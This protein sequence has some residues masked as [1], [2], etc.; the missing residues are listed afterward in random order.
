MAT[1]EAQVDVGQGQA[2]DH[3]MPAGPQKEHEWLQKLVGEWTYETEMPMGPD[4]PVQK[5]QGT[6]RVRSIGGLWVV[7]EGQGEMPG[8]GPATMIVTIG[9]DPQKKSY[10]GTWV[11]S[12]M[13]TLWIY[14]GT[15]DAAEKVLTLAADGPKMTAEGPG[16]G[17]AKY[18][19]V[20][21]F[22]SDDRRTLTSRILGDDGEW[23]QIMKAHYR[24]VG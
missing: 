2:T 22:E 1:S 16:E 19:D 12:M 13:T 24:R 11:G 14:N 5:F 3:C 21:E 7:G 17:T 15:L 9:Y 20:I 18:Q 23:Q 10:V 4:Q 6:E 8:G